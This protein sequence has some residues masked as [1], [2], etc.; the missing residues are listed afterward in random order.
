MDHKPYKELPETTVALPEVEE[1]LPHTCEEFSTW[2][3]AEL[4]Q[5]EERFRPFWVRRR[6]N[7][8][9]TTRGVKIR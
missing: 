3:D 1:R 5:L 4:V 2:M 7:D 8:V 9:L 6:S